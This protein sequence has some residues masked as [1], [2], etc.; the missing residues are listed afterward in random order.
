MVRA[1]HAARTRVLSA[2]RRRAAADRRTGR[3]HARR[4]TH[5]RDRRDRY[6]TR[7]ARRGGAPRALPALART[8]PHGCRSRGGSGGAGPRPAP[9]GARGGP[10]LSPPRFGHG[11]R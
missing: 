11:E 3:G 1:R 10:R 2:R 5:R 7:R 9:R 6:G 4:R 8:V